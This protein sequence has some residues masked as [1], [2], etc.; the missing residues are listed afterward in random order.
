MAAS[1]SGR[2]SKTFRE[3]LALIACIFVLG[4][5]SGTGPTD[6]LALI[7]AE[8]DAAVAGG[9][10]DRIR[11]HLAHE[12]PAVR[13]LAAQAT[14]VAADWDSMP[15]LIELI[16]DDDPAVRARALAAC[17][18]LIGMDHGHDPLATPA[19]RAKA[20]AT[21]ARAYETMRRNPPPQYRK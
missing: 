10:V 13:A 9:D 2:S 17:A 11:A 4:C 5:G 1:P 14:A 20:K 8:L 6:P 21:V 19:D 3:S 12:T 16:D 15:R 18:A 7:A